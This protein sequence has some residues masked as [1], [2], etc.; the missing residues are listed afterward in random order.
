MPPA[1]FELIDE[2]GVFDGEQ[3]SILD[4]RE[5]A[6]VVGAANYYALTMPGQTF[7]FTVLRGPSGSLPSLT[8]EETSQIEWADDR[9]VIGSMVFRSV[10]HTTRSSGEAEAM[11][12]LTVDVGGAEQIAT[13]YN[14]LPGVLG[15]VRRAVRFSAPVQFDALRQFRTDVIHWRNRS[16]HPSKASPVLID[17]GASA[18]GPGKVPAVLFGIHWL[19]L[20][21]AERWAVETV[22]L[23]KEAGLVPIVV[24]DRPSS[25]PWITRPEFDGAV[26][27]PL[28]MPLPPGQESSFLN[29]VLSAFDVRGVHLHHCTW[30]YERLPWLK[31][32]RPDIPVVDSLHIL[33]YRTGGFVDISVRMSNV[34]D[35]HHVIS[36][37]L[38]D[39]LIGKQ[40]V[41]KDKVALATLANLTVRA[42]DPKP[43]PSTDGPF[44]VAFVGRFTQQKRPYL[45]LKLAAELKGSA[46]GD[47]RF[48]MHGDGELSGEVH[49][50]RNRLGL[51]DV[52]EIRGPDQPVSR[53]LAESDVLVISSDNEGL[54]LTSFEASAAGVPVVSA[55][56]GSQ[57]SLI[58]DELLCPRHPYPFIR[59]AAD[60]I[61]TMMTDPQQRETWLAE[62]R[63]KSEAFAA[64]PDARSMVRDL[65]QGWM[66]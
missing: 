3:P 8:D 27:V 29:G 28:T 64:L 38:R 50:L 5:R 47:I 6:L 11:I 2:S 10:V 42:E 4:D 18:V 34:I 30:L 59:T 21:G 40:N 17:R 44:T 33:E 20:G 48:V 13:A 16:E 1:T 63:D 9:Q 12:D 53:T 54:T 37:Q 19:E 36:P 15:A 41:D 35:T 23:A 65:Y 39:Y 45:F 49:G 14:Q 32:V 22:Q 60:R 56:V 58:A 46:P 31:A 51:A 55:D 61:A 66:Q 24:T 62:Q 25:H 57:A 7:R 52:L 26:V 43:A